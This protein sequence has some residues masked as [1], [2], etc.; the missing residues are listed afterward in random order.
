MSSDIPQFQ[1]RH[2]RSRDAFRPI[3]CEQKYLMD[4]THSQYVLKIAVKARQYWLLKLIISFA[5]HLRSSINI[6]YQPL[7][8]R[9]IV[10]KYHT[11]RNLCIFF[12]C[13]FFQPFMFGAASSNA[14]PASEETME[15]DG[16]S[17]SSNLFGPA[18]AVQL[19]RWRLGY[20]GA[21]QKL[22][23]LLSSMLYHSYL[24]FSDK[25]VTLL[26]QWPVICDSDWPM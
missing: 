8:L 11:F 19:R 13:V 7:S 15:A 25:R 12:C 21:L 23:I 6:H 10:V 1:L 5:C 4:Q 20:Q 16:S 18:G 17:S 26:L 22:M 3:A 14:T 2:L 24:F 9:R